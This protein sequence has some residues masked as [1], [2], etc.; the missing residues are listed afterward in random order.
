MANAPGAKSKQN[1]SAYWDSVYKFRKA[2]TTNVS[3]ATVSDMLRIIFPDFRLKIIR[4]FYGAAH[5]NATKTV[6]YLIAA[7]QLMPVKSIVE[8][9]EKLGELTETLVSGE[10]DHLFDLKIC[11]EVHQLVAAMSVVSNE[12]IHGSISPIHMAALCDL[13]LAVQFLIDIGGSTET[14]DMEGAT[15]M[16]ISASLNRA[17]I[18][19]ALCEKGANVEFRKKGGHTVLFSTVAA[20][21]REI[22]DILLEFKADPNVPHAKTGTMPLWIACS[23]GDFLCAEALLNAGA[24]KN[25]PVNMRSVVEMDDTCGE[26]VKAVMES[27]EQRGK[28]KKPEG[29]GKWSEEDGNNLMGVLAGVST[30]SSP[31]PLSGS[32]SGGGGGSVVTK[33]GATPMWIAACNGHDKLV[34]MLLERGAAP[35]LMCDSTSPLW[36]AASNG[37]DKVVTA[38]CFRANLESRAIDGA[39]PLWVAAEHG[40]VECVRVLLDAGA[41]IDSRT[42]DQRTALHIAAANR[43]LGVVLM[44]LRGGANANAMAIDGSTPVH[45]L[46][47]KGHSTSAAG[48]EDMWEEV[49]AAL[50]E[51][52]V[53]MEATKADGANVLHTAVRSGDHTQVKYIVDKGSVDPNQCSEDGLSPLHEATLRGDVECVRALLASEELEVDVRCKEGAQHPGATALWLAAKKGHA[54][55]VE[56]LLAGGAS[57]NCACKD[58]TPLMVSINTGHT[59]CISLIQMAT[60]KLIAENKKAEFGGS[61]K[62][63]KYPTFLLKM[64]GKR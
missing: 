33:G 31:S 37:H 35:E 59:N 57:V 25:E 3:E 52:G 4:H 1:V 27:L 47:S 12:M 49:L 42:I 43:H 62:V 64:G 26:A 38:L 53:Q 30:A 56:V 15:P 11:E 58:V 20:G 60:K 39:T 63:G 40:H 17:N 34:S 10:A 28:L 46:M 21:H 48:S 18:V 36:I 50:L 55:V 22:L 32:G 29:N 23:N 61:A 19:R 24:F 5:Q 13:P 14:L 7:G 9:T 41:K 2:S 16:L 44:L 54:K 8:G 6:G 45:L 51:A